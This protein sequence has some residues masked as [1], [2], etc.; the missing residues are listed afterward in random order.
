MGVWGD[1]WNDWTVE[2]ADY[3]D[4][5]DRVLLVGKQRGRAAGSDAW[6]EQPLCLVYLLRGGMVVEVRA[7]FDVDQARDA[8]GLAE[9]P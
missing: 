1:A 4:A 6:V 3:V 5:G 9:Q 7:F 8:A 2:L